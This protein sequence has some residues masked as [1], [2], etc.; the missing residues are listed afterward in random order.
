MRLN[1]DCIR[2]ALIC[3]EEH[4]GIRTSCVFIYAGPEG[5]AVAEALGKPLE[6]P[7]YQIQLIEKFGNDQLLYHVQYCIE[8]NL[9]KG[10]LAGDRIIIADLTPTGHELLAK[11]RDPERWPKV[12]KGMAAVRDYSIAAL[13]SVAEGMTSAAI[14]ALSFGQM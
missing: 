8:A 14:N 1:H 3:I 13:G 4:T 2:E 11:I 7:E 10:D 9:A 5:F 6:I 12:K